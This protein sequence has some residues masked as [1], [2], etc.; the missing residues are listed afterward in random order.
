MQGTALCQNRH[1]LARIK[2]LASAMPNQRH[3]RSKTILLAMKL[4]AFILL[5]ACLHVSAKGTTQVTF[6]GKDVPLEKVFEAIKKQTGYSFLYNSDAIKKAKP[7]TI[8][9]KDMAVEEVLAECLRGQPFNFRVADRTIFILPKKNEVSSEPNQNSQ[10]IDLKQIDVTGRVVNENGEPVSG[11]TVTIKGTKAITTTNRNGEFSLHS[12]DPDAVLVFTHV[13]LETFEVKVSGKTELAIGLRTKVSALEDVTVTL[14]TGYEKLPKERATGSFEFINSE[15]INRRV[16]TDILSRL[17][18]VT[19]SVLFDKRGISPSVTTIPLNNVII[20]GLSTLTTSP[21]SVRQPLI[22]VNN[23][24][25]EGNINN[26]NPNDVESITILKDAAAASIYGARA[27]NGVIVISTKQGQFNNAMKLILVT[28]IQT[29][30]KPNLFELPKMSSSEFIDVETFL[31]NEGFYEGL[32]DNPQHPALSPIVEIL[33]NRRNGLIS[34]TDSSTQINS[35]RGLDLRNDFQKYIY[36]KALLQQYS[37][38]VSGGGEK[39]KYSISGGLDKNLSSLVGDRY[40]RLTF[41]SDNSF[42][43]SKQMMF[44]IG[45]R[46][47]NTKIEN[48]S[49]GELGSNNYYFRTTTGGSQEIYPYAQFSDQLGSYSTIPKDWRQEYADT[50]GNGNLLDWKYRPLQELENADNKSAERD[51]VLNGNIT[52]KI[53]PEISLSGNYQFQE[54]NGE[55]RNHYNKETYFVRNLINLYT[56]LSTTNSSERNPIPLGGILDHTTY[57]LMSH[58]ARAQ[59]NFNYLWSKKH[60]FNAL[61]GSEIK[62]VVRN[63]S[64]KR[65]YGYN[66]ER[67]TTSLVDQVNL[68]PLYGDRGTALIPTGPNGFE[69]LTDHFVSFLGNAAYTYDNRYTVSASARMDAANILGLYVKDKWKPFWSI[70]GAWIVSNE[71]FFKVKPI[72]YLKL[73]GNIGYQGNVNNSLAP[74]TII[75]YSSANSVF[76]LPFA[77]ISSPGNPGLNWEIMR[78]ANVGVDFRVLNNRLSASLELYKK[79]SDNL[80]LTSEVD[81][82]TG[83]TG[84]KKNS[85]SMTGQGID[86]TLNSSNIRGAF[87]WNTELGIAFADNQVKDHEL[88]QTTLSAGNVVNSEGLFI[89]T[90]KGI[91]PYPIF[92]YPFAG[93]NPNTGDPQGFLGKTVSDN[94]FEISNQQFD[95]ANIIYHGSGI[96]TKFGYLNN[97]I[98]YRGITLAVSV[99]YRFGYYFRK[100]TISYNRLYEAGIQHPDFGNRWRQPGDEMHT[101]IPSMIYPLP[102]AQRDN[103]YA[104]SSANVFKGDNIRLEYIR[105]GY[106][107]NNS[108]LRK[109]FVKSITVSCNVQNLGLLWKANKHGLDPDYNLG[110]ARYLVP[111]RISIGAKFDF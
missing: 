68:F 101:T 12:V 46:F 40:E 55:F 65:V 5:I 54:S 18:G 11:V 39:I 7:V 6:S 3:P 2:G 20:R 26:I 81:A 60:Q 76:N 37:L 72:S 58:F 66:D 27:A 103:F 33:L 30:Q 82:T 89:T 77:S 34:P 59:L 50:A 78:H 52:Y 109:T 111:K 110:N 69:K 61:I 38:N 104:Y 73:R 9:V 91:S 35:L 23:I 107:I 16:S 14:N 105:L 62:E 95:T 99:S 42:V 98:T 17:E 92:S 88:D 21:E 10:I 43:A 80:I 97:V 85:A 13:S 49:L 71:S 8:D 64:G 56:N 75:S 22:V 67:L 19:T 70:G 51:L 108:L 79:S 57:T 31:F 29:T 48:S 100:N 63:S 74:Y 28:N 90:I 47:T 41:V 44:Q 1:E 45:V 4:T 84:I 24:P 36:R 96:P 86:I 106:I 87:S 53:S 15:E 93:L 32:I 83:V 102:D 94:Y 25:Y